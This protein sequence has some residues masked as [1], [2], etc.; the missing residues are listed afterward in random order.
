MFY[1]RDIEA[2]DQEF[3]MQQ[4]LGEEAAAVWNE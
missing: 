3:N 4:F 1:A 2:R